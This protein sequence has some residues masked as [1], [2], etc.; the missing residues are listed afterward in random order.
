MS[1]KRAQ[2]APKKR[3]RPPKA[4]NSDDVRADLVIA[5]TAHRLVMWGF[6]EAQ[7]FAAVAQGDAR[8]RSPRTVERVYQ[9]DGPRW[10]RAPYTKESLQRTIP[11]AAW[12]LQPSPEP[13]RPDETD[14]E[15]IARWRRD[16]LA[17]RLDWLGVLARH[18]LR[19]GGEWTEPG[20]GILNAELSGPPAWQRTERAEKAHAAY[21]AKMPRITGKNVRNK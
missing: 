10:P 7:V 1:G 3:G 4:A 18:L 15:G 13:P 20:D 17:W 9:R 16:H 8:G 12:A 19:H 14:L 6:P 2:S 11:T 5:Y 21:A